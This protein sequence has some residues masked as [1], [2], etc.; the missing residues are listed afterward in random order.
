MG[1]HA[2]KTVTGTLFSHLVAL[3]VCLISVPSVGSEEELPLDQQLQ[4]TSPWIIDVDTS[5]LRPYLQY[6]GSAMYNP[7]VLRVTYKKRNQDFTWEPQTKYED[8]WYKNGNPIGLRRYSQ[9]V[10]QQDGVI[11]VQPS[12]LLRESPNAPK[13]IGNAIARIVLD[14]LTTKVA[15]LRTAYVP[16][17]IFEETISE[18]SNLGFSQFSTGSKGRTV[19]IHLTSYPQGFDLYLRH[20]NLTSKD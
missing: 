19:M 15:T 18:L 17:D 9:L 14:V 4:S 12:Q 3:L 10:V 7:L 11:Y 13:A 6:S 5:L 16:K 1:W 20:R 8:L 2:L